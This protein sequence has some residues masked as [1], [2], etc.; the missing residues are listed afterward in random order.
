[1]KSNEHCDVLCQLPRVVLA[2]HLITH[3]CDTIYYYTCTQCFIKR[4][5]PI[6]V[7]R[8]QTSRRKLA[9]LGSFTAF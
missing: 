8:K 2:M 5:T 9:K 7:C 4:G 6:F 1:V 3:Q